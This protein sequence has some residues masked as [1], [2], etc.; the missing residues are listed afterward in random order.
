[1]LMKKSM[2]ALCCSFVLGLAASPVEDVKTEQVKWEY[3]RE[4]LSSAIS[5]QTGIVSK[6]GWLIKN[7]AGI[8]GAVVS[9]IMVVGGMIGGSLVHEDLSMN[10]KLKLSKEQEAFFVVG[11]SLGIG[12]ISGII[13]Y[14]VAQKCGG[15]LEAKPAICK[16]ALVQFMQQWQEHE[17]HI[18]QDVR[19]LFERLNN[20]FDQTTG[21][22]RTLNDTAA[23]LFVEN[24]LT[25]SIVVNALA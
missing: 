13:A 14:Y 15:W 4:N 11:I 18:P 19:A 7:T 9:A 17:A 1:M 22:F 5:N 25:M 21:T 20:D 6:A 3:V 8:D 23:H 10:L 16:K 2:I 24:M 12:A